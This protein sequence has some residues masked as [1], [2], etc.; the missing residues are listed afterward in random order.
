[1]VKASGRV[2][3]RNIFKQYPASD[4]Y[5]GSVEL[6]QE[7]IAERLR[8]DFEDVGL[9][10]KFFGLRS[11]RKQNRKHPPATEAANNEVW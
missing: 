2:H 3:A 6:A 9:E 8:Q 5:S 4:L 11:I 7:Q 10:L 1:M